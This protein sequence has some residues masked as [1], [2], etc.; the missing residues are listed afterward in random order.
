MCEPGAYRVATRAR[1]YID[2]TV[3]GCILAKVSLLREMNHTTTV[4][5]VLRKGMLHTAAY[6]FSIST[7]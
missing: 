5:Y 1:G 4:P 7:E 6:F 2:L 3:R